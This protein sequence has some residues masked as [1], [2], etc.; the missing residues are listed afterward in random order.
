VRRQTRTRFEIELRVAEARFT[1]AK[2][3]VDGSPGREQKYQAA[4]KDLWLA[5]QRV[6][7][8]QPVYEG[9]NGNGVARPQALTVG[10]KEGN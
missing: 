9:S 6:R 2:A 10:I 5:R 1:R 8:N 4:K 3:A 7:R